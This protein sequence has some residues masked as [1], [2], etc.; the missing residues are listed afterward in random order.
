M[1]AS[2]TSD[3]S[4]QLRSGYNLNIA[5][6][7]SQILANVCLETTSQPEKKLTPS[8][9]QADDA[10][11][12]YKSVSVMP[13]ESH[14]DSAAAEK[15]RAQQQSPSITK[16]ESDDPNRDSNQ[17]SE[18][19][20]VITKYVRTTSRSI[21]TKR[22]SFTYRQASADASKVPAEKQSARES[23]AVRSQSIVEEQVSPANYTDDT[24]QGMHS[25]RHSISHL[26]HEPTDWE[27]TL[28]QSAASVNTP[29]NSLEY[30]RQQNL[31]LHMADQRHHSNVEDSVP[32]HDIPHHSI[33]PRERLSMSVEHAHARASDARSLTEGNTPRNS[34]DA[35]DHHDIE[36]YLSQ[37]NGVH[38]DNVP[39]DSHVRER[40]DANALSSQFQT[41]AANSTSDA[42]TKTAEVG[43]EFSRKQSVSFKRDQA[44]T[45]P[46]TADVDPCQT[47][48]NKQHYRSPECDL[49]PF[50]PKLVCD[51]EFK[52]RFDS[53]RCADD[54]FG[55]NRQ[56]TSSGDD[57]PEAALRDNDACYTTSSTYMED[58]EP[59]MLPY[60]P[61]IADRESEMLINGVT[62]V[63]RSPC[64]SAQYHQMQ[65]S[66]DEKREEVLKPTENG[67]MSAAIRR[68]SRE[69]P[70]EIKRDSR[71]DP[72]EVRR[73]SRD[74]PIEIKRDS[75]DVPSEVRRDSRDVPMEVKR[76]SRDVPIEIKRDGRDVPSEVRRDSRDVPIEIKRDSRDVPIEIERDGRDVPITIARDSRDVS[77]EVH[78]RNEGTATTERVVKTDYKDIIE[79]VQ[80]IHNKRSSSVPVTD[81]M[82]QTRRLVYTTVL[83]EKCEVIEYGKSLDT[84]VGGISPA[85]GSCYTEMESDDKQQAT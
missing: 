49:P 52:A 59:V 69:V 15:S 65:Q 85:S 51:I 40:S 43:Q 48:I 83:R 16:R 63:D 66:N 14:D 4:E 29:R 31:L 6:R 47:I 32:H 17:Q 22:E 70:I 74:V 56:E 24:Q 78:K 55:R 26:E 57:D 30:A 72:S 5:D 58:A 50:D 33:P 41:P 35:H 77:G 62:E 19:R 10:Q 54:Q 20:E 84:F 38:D 12:N 3:E 67:D 42:R 18:Q 37:R 45:K 13:D 53:Q 8:A 21:T 68:G 39:P 36:T 23:V 81:E 82:Q 1:D 61:R 75:R 34:F 44:S 28:R 7:E 64:T 27:R 80:I 11:I 46:Q 2:V 60:D 25:D 71:D 9:Q 76:D 73:D 79:P